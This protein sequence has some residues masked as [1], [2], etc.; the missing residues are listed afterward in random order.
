MNGTVFEDSDTMKLLPI[1]LA[2]SILAPVGAQQTT[3][4][5]PTQPVDPAFEGC[6]AKGPTDGVF[7]LQNARAVSGTIVGTGLRL[8]LVADNKGIELLPHLNH[9]VQV[10]GPVEGTVPTPPTPEKPVP[11]T[12]LPQVRVKAVSM[13][14]NECIVP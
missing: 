7:L 6:L 1:L 14:S 3:Q 9:V 5:K 11:D 8:R 2:A 10:S 13:I 4:E 12:E